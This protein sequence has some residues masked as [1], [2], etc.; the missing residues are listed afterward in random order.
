MIHNEAIESQDACVEEAGIAVAAQEKQAREVFPLLTDRV[1][2]ASAPLFV[3]NLRRG[4]KV[5]SEWM[6]G[7]ELELFGYDLK[8]DYARI[9]PAQV[10]RVLAGFAPNSNDLVYEENV[11]IEVDAGQMNRLTVEPGGQVEFSGAPQRD[12]KDVEREISRYLARLHEISEG[13][14]LAFLAVGF[15]PIRKLGEQCWFPKGRYEVMRP[16]LAKRGARAW[17]MMTRT[18]ATQASMD[19]GSTGDLAKKFLLGNRLAPIVTAIFANSPFE[20]GRLSGYKSTRAAAW[21]ETDSARTGVSPPALDDDFSPDTFVAYALEVP[22]IFAQREGRY[23]NAPTGMKF[24]DFLAQGCDSVEPV[25]GDWADHLTT[26]FTEARL[27]QHIELRSADCGTLSHVLALQAL[28][29]GLLYDANSLDEALRLAPKLSAEKMRELQEQVARYGLA[30][31]VEKIEVLSMAKEIVRLAR[32][33]LER[34]APSE[35]SYLDVI[36]EQV[37]EDEICPADILLRNWEGAWHGSMQRVLEYLRI[38]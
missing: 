38:A 34:I 4:A 21:L 15:D 7:V 26:L 12:L 35:A 19:Y 3:E 30:A 14:C 25:F 6:C 2:L 13:G 33:G 11:L 1:T 28:W 9:N 17:D 5:R 37:I 36:Q 16:Y 10:Q 29:K 23:L 27:K 31:R 20:D 32:N 18:C 24:G 8:R 22:M